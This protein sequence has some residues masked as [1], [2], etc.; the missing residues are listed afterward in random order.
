MVE[1]IIWFFKTL[2]KFIRH[3]ASLASAFNITGNVLVVIVTTGENSRGKR[4]DQT[5]AFKAYQYRWDWLIILF[6][7][8]RGIYSFKIF[9]QFRQFIE[10]IEQSIKKMIH[11]VSI[12]AMS[13]FMFAAMN[14]AIERDNVNSLLSEPYDGTIDY[15]PKF[16]YMLGQ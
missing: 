11:F 14:Y 13:I 16:Y 12:T 10:M 5:I 15:D 9:T 4:G 1:N 6:I 2:W 7:M 3:E 8:L